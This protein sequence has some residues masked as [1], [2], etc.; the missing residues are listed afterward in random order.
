M[1]LT[2][3]FA[4]QLRHC[5]EQRT[6]SQ[7]E[8]ADQAGLDRTYVSQLE[9]A[10]KSPTL[11]TIEKVARCLHVSPENLLREQIT[12]T[13]SQGF[14]VHHDYHL[15]EINQISVRRTQTSIPIPSSIFLSAIDV[16]HHLIDQLYS[17]ELDVASVLGPRNL[18]AFIGELYAGAVIKEAGGLFRRNP[19]QD[20]YPDL[21]LMDDV[22]KQE[23]AGLQ[24]RMNEKAPFSPFPTG[25]IEVKATCGSVPTPQVC[26]R[27]G[28]PRPALGDTRIHCLTGYD[29]KAH[30][31]ETNNLLGILWDFIDRKPRIAALFYSSNLTIKDWGEIVRPHTGGGRTT[32]VSIMNS[33]GIAHMY[34]GWL[35]VLKEGQYAHFLNRK[36]RAELIPTS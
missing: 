1:N 21:L 33:T 16:A 28:T 8:L 29:W 6:I 18:S 30:P 22:G 34:A 15:R 5:R 20:G 36:N 24:D 19:H 27:R 23:W 35:C 32:S 14:V 9:R 2:E 13:S 11:T 12:T 25:G 4:R 7:E 10:L 17:L 3:R 26:R 31:R